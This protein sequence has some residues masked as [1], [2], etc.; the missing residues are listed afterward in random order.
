MERHEASHIKEGTIPCTFPGCTKLFKTIK[1]MRNHLKV[2][3]DARPFNCEFCSKTFKDGRALRYHKGIHAD[4]Q[5]FNCEICG[6]IRDL[7]RFI[8]ASD[9]SILGKQFPV[10]SALKSHQLTHTDDKPFTCPLCFHRFKRRHDMNF[11]IYT[12]HY[13][14]QEETKAKEAC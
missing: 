14:S 13:G 11:H 2:H 10:F 9:S 7:N 1:N 5:D 3:S 8:Q 12:Q 6:K 4:V